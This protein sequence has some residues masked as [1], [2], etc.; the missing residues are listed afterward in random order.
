MKTL[1]PPLL[2]LFIGIAVLLVYAGWQV[3]ARRSGAVSAG[4][5]ASSGPIDRE[6]GHGRDRAQYAIAASWLEGC[7]GDDDCVRVDA[8]CCGLAGGGRCAFVPRRHVVD[9]AK[10][11]VAGCRDVACP[12]V[13]SQDPTCHG[14]AVCDQGRCRVVDAQDASQ[15]G[16]GIKPIE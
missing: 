2:A 4:A 15:F 10:A 3:E 9:Q 14:R 16:I 13:V 12:S 7:A 5:D 1:S 6:A 8:D 11:R